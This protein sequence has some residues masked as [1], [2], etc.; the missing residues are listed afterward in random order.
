MAYA[1]VGPFAHRTSSFSTAD[2]VAESH[3]DAQVGL[4]DLAAA[5]GHLAPHAASTGGDEHHRA[6]RVPRTLLRRI[7]RAAAPSASARRPPPSLTASIGAPSML[8]TTTSTPPSSSKS[9]TAEPRDDAR[10]AS[11]RPAAAPTSSNRVPFR[12]RSSSARCAYEV[13]QGSAIG[14]RVDVA[15]DDERGRASRRCRSRGSSCP[16]RGTASTRARRPS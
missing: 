9:P 4:R 1:T 3:V 8:F 10:R 15:V 12:L 6:D 5:A 7:A 14:R 2:R 13:F 11:A 16:S